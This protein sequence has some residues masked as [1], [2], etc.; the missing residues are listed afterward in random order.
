MRARFLTLMG[1]YQTSEIRIT[2]AYLPPRVFIPTPYLPEAYMR[3][4]I[5]RLIVDAAYSLVVSLKLMK[6][7]IEN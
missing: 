5:V 2:L 7:R 3:Q 4:Q 1:A 6:P